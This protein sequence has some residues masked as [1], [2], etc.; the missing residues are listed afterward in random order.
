MATM[1]VEEALNW[2]AELFEEPNNLITP[3]TPLENVPTWD[4]VGILTLIAELDEKCG[5]ILSGEHMQDMTKI[6]DILEILRQN[7]A[8]G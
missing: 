5:V 6:D 2:I 3:E 4:S 1:T 7:G 8:L